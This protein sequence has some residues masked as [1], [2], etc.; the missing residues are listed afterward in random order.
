[1][2]ILRKFFGMNTVHF[3][4]LSVE[5]DRGS[6]ELMYIPKSLQVLAQDIKKE[7]PFQFKF[8]SKFFPEDVSEELIQEV[9]Q[10]YSK[11]LQFLIT[12]PGSQK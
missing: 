7:T 1:M 11:N 4:S 3:I 12:I 9:T 10:V 8:R 6:I 2:C 5:S